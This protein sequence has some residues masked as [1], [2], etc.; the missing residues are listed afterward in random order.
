MRIVKLL[1][2]AISITFSH[3][4]LSENV[5]SKGVLDLS[6]IQLSENKSLKLQGEIEFYWSNLFTPDQLQT[7]NDS[8]KPLMV[9]IPKSWSSYV[10]NGKKLP[11]NG[12]GTY[13]FW[14]DL[15]GTNSAQILSLKIPT[16]FSSYKLWVDNKLIAEAGTVATS[17]DEHK[18]G[19][20][21][22]NIPFSF[23]PSGNNV[24]RIEIVIQVSN[25]SH[26]R[27]GIAWPIFIGSYN[28]IKD[29]SRNLDILNLIVLG[30]ILIIGLNHIN[31]FLFRRK[32]VS[33]LYFGILTLVM[34]L[35]NITTGDRL[36]G[37]LLPS[38]D[39]ELMLKL[40]NFSGYGTI[41]FFALFIFH[42][43]RN[44]F[45]SWI[46]TLMVILGIIISVIIFATPAATFGKFNLFFELYLLIGGLYLTFGVLL[47]ATIRKRQG[48]FLTFLGMFILYAT[49]IN[50]V[51]SSMTIIQTA[52][53]APYGLVTFML[54]Q[55][56]NI[57][58]KSAKAINQNEELSHQLANEKEGLERSIE[59]RTKELQ[60]QHNLLIEH[61]EKEKIQNWINTG[62]AK[63]NNILSTDKSD[64]AVLC[65][66]VLTSI[67]KYMDVKLGALYVISDDDSHTLQMVANFGASK[68][69]SD[70]NRFIEMGSGLVGATYIDNQLQVLSNI[71]ENYYKI[72]SG[73]GNSAPRNMLLAP[74]STDEAVVGVLELARFDEFKPEEL[75]FIKKIAYS[76]ASNLNTVRMNERNVNLIQ[77]FQEQREEIQEKEEQMR[78][79]LHEL[80][81]LREQYEKLKAENDELKKKKK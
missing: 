74:L 75:E 23:I 63:I 7:K 3:T 18:P 70:N 31:M 78:E 27:A 66:N 34:I 52:Y 46:K 13:R 55:S 68:Q 9:N 21:I 57:T 77:Q 6:R 71:P 11:S 14:I 62:L 39:W 1:I 38:I 17:K 50:D 45:R 41:P 49:A 24:D 22:D 43:Y 58:S 76:I 51:L 2:F 54:L 48:A 37:Y 4:L 72:N 35:R 8:I 19:F 25:F 53:V 30:V 29:A 10:V 44:D 73:L 15:K 47:I 40:D 79:N 64:F 32:D 16:I 60:Q 61:Q 67:V 20:L 81:Y 26:R 36:L 33:N 69:L 5:I 59:E 80:E 12:Y 42:L 56:F 65:S 28:A